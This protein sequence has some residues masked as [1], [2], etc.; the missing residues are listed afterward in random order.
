M[1]KLELKILSS[2]QGYPCVVLLEQIP[3]V[4]REMFCSLDLYGGCSMCVCVHT[5]CLSADLS[6]LNLLVL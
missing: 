6:F 5:Y 1:E 4:A 2:K 3:V